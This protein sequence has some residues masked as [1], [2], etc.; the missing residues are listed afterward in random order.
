MNAFAS[1]LFNW[2]KELGYQP[3]QQYLEERLLSHPY[4]TTARAITDSLS[5]LGIES[6]AIELPLEEAYTLNDPFFTLLKKTRRQEDQWAMLKFVDKTAHISTPENNHTAVTL[7]ELNEAWSG[8]IIVADKSI[9]SK[10][11][12]SAKYLN[13][14]A[15]ITLLCCIATLFLLQLPDILLIAY[16]TA[17]IAG[18]AVSSML[19]LLQTN[20]SRA[21]LQP[22]C[23]ISS[24]INCSAILQSASSKLY[25]NISWT[26]IGI[27]FFS[28]QIFS[29]LLSNSSTQWWYISLIAAVFPVYSIYQQVVILKKWC[30]LCLFVVGLLGLQA[31]I[32]SYV[33]Y[34]YPTAAFFVILKSFLP[35]IPIGVMCCIGW[36]LIKPFFQY[37]LAIHRLKIENTSFKRNIHLFSAHYQQTLALS[38]QQLQQYPVIQLGNERSAVQLTLITNPVCEH[39]KTAYHTLQLLL[40]QYHNQLG[41]RI[42][43]Y[44]SEKGLATTAGAIAT[45]LTGIWLQN[46]ANGE[47]LINDWYTNQHLPPD[48]SAQQ[49]Q[50]PYLLARTIVENNLTWCNQNQL[51]LTPLL[52]INNKPFPAWYAPGDI[53]NFIEEVMILENVAGEAKPNPA[54][55]QQLLVDTVST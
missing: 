29:L 19:F 7:T 17:G 43:F 31:A 20:H 37:K 15:I 46:A 35:L 6:L 22:F 52:L 21:W 4:P 49:N 38:T 47:K 27:L 13:A 53:V 11:R 51:R 5:E 24:T 48:T 1:S 41:I 30:P 33:L 44:V 10:I 28:V 34:N 25:R 14:A 18:L 42:V 16:F 54:F 55:P 12:V 40:Q 2:L 36:F 23:Q 39:C 3:N 26:D 50:P 8:I 32:S 9:V 45:K